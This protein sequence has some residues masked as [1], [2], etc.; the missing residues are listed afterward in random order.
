MLNILL[1]LFGDD[2]KGAEL[3]GGGARVG[4]AGRGVIRPKSTSR[5]K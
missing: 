4:V 2:S 1:V 3:Q 5:A